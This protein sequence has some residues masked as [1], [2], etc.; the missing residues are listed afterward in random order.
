MNYRFV[1]KIL[2]LENGQRIVT[3]KSITGTEEYFDEHFP[4]FYSVPNSLIIESLADSAALLIFA[5]TEFKA[6]ALL[7][8]VNDVIFEK[9]VKPGDQLLFNVRLVSLHDDAAQFDGK[10]MVGEDLA[11]RATMTLGLFYLIDMKDKKNRD[12]FTSLLQR[13]ANFIREQINCLHTSLNRCEF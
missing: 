4:R 5:T 11:A 7:I 8:M 1:D 6:L 2:E 3:Q 12:N 10:V 9:A 13:S